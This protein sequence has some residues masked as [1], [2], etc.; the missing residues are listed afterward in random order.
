[1]T[2][3]QPPICG[4]HKREKEWR[5]TVFTYNEDGISIHI[6]NIYAWVCPEDDDV[7]FTPETADELIVALREFVHAANVPKRDVL[8]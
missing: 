3:K 2:P 5:Q 8:C 7:S 1:M 4:E 6:P